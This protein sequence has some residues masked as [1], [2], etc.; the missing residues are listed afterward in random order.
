MRYGVDLTTPLSRIDKD[1]V[2]EQWN[3]GD[4]AAL[5][6]FKYNCNNLNGDTKKF[7]YQKV[8][9][10]RAWQR[11]TSQAKDIK[12]SDNFLDGTV[13]RANDRIRTIITRIH[14]LLWNLFA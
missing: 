9:N 12:I 2:P 3:E 14:Q 4:G 10:Q 7:E 1:Y 6:R 13:N 5:I 11:L 8:L